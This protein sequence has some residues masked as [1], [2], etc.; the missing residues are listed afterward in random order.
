VVGEGPPVFAQA[1]GAPVLYLGA[2]PPAPEGEAI[3]VRKD[4]PL[5]SVADLRGKHVVLNKGANVHYLLLKALEEAGVAYGDLKISF[6]PP[7]GA[8]AAFE[9]GQVDAWAIWDPFLASV[10]EATGAR[11]LRD[12]QGLAQNPAYYIGTRPFVEASPQLVQIFLDEVRTTGA[13]TNQNHPKVVALLSP[14]LGIKEA[15]LAKALAR[16]RFGLRAVDDELLAGQQKVADTFH[17]Q[18]LIPRAIRV[19]DA[20]WKSPRV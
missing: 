1:A 16:N 14:L 12:G 5:K 4:S 6:V 3:I 10:E 20:R 11:V 8:R 15:A 2:E 19:L 18:K 17:A 9:S 13:W 7:A